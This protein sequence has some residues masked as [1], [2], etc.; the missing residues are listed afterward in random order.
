MNLSSSCDVVLVGYRAADTRAALGLCH[1]LFG[2]A[3]EGRRLLVLNREGLAPEVQ[4]QAAG[5]QLVAGSNRHAEFSGWQEGLDL[6]AGS[7]GNK[8]AVVFVN[9]SVSTHRHFTS[10]RGHAFLRTLEATVGRE[11]VG[12]QDR[13]ERSTI[14]VRPDADLELTIADMTLFAWTSTYC[15]ALTSEALQTLQCLL[16]DS[17][18]VEAC[19][20]GGV[21]EATFFSRLSPHLAEHLRGWLFAGGWYGGGRLTSE[22]MVRLQMKAR[23]IAAELLLSARCRTVGIRALDPF[24]LH[25]MLARLDRYSTRLA[26]TL[27][28]HSPG[29]RLR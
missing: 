4:P 12:F 9:D 18:Q 5:W 27:L 28:R 6:L 7:L 16:Y 1:R 17:A 15:F 14:S 23:S 24:L 29:S 26:T 13:P 3:R 8:A 19:V 25:P 11:L 20:P 22:N 21:D 10:A 2:P